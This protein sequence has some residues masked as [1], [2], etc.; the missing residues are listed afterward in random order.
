MAA[1]LKKKAED[2]V[3]AALRVGERPLSRYVRRR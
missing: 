2:E 1:S 3:K